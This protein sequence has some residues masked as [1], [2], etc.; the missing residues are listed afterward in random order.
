MSSPI[1]ELNGLRCALRERRDNDTNLILQSWKGSCWADANYKPY[2]RKC[3]EVLNQ[4]C[5]KL[6]G[7]SVCM[8]AVAENDDNHIFGWACGL[9]D[10]LHFVYV[11]KA[12]R[13]NGLASVLVKSLKSTT[14]VQCTHWT[15]HAE[16]IQAAGKEIHYTP[17]ALRPG[18]LRGS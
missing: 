8:V 14:P 18:W 13:R 6:L 17:S 15:I 12:Y 3:W 1:V 5:G 10:V 16:Q 2:G 4:Q 11:C 9:P 7:R